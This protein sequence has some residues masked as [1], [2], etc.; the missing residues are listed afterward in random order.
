MAF[1]AELRAAGVAAAGDEGRTKVLP[2][3]AMVSCHLNC[4]ACGGDEGRVGFLLAAAAEELAAAAEQPAV[5]RAAETTQKR[6]Q[7]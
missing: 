2:A 5:A 7:T 1:R 6:V 4:K 3:A